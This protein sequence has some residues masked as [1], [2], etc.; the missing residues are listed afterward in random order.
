MRRY[1]SVVY[2]IV[3]CLYVPVTLRY[4]T[5]IKTAKHRMMQ[6]SPEFSD[7][8]DHGKLATFDKQLAITLKRYNI[9]T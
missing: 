6:Y 4:C 5:G 7:A 8:K 1:A 2:A 9:D 3:M